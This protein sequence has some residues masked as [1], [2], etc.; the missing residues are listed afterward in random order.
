MDKNLRQHAG[1]THIAA[2]QAAMPLVLHNAEHLFCET[3]RT[4]SDIWPL[5]EEIS[6]WGRDPVSIGP[7]VI[8]SLFVIRATHIKSASVSVALQHL[9]AAGFGARCVTRAEKRPIDC[10]FWIVPGDEIRKQFEKNERG[11]RNLV[12]VLTA[13]AGG[14]PRNCSVRATGLVAG[15]GAE[16][17]P[18]PSNLAQIQSDRA[19]SAVAHALQLAETQA[20]ALD[21][22]S[23]AGIDP[24]MLVEDLVAPSASA[25]SATRAFE[26]VMAIHAAYRVPGAAHALIG[27]DTVRLWLANSAILAGGSLDRVKEIVATPLAGQKRHL[28]KRIVETTLELALSDPRLERSVRRRLRNYS[29]FADRQT[30]HSSDK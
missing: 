7:A 24:L 15:L 5:A 16:I 28:P 23:K 4:E 17:V 21:A 22:L 8:G 13:L 27:S 25:E 29:I 18:V 6:T 30:A 10:E 20:Q 3:L 26:D 9:S 12:A 1:R 2:I 14:D 19:A 11:L